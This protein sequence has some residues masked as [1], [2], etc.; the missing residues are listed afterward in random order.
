MKCVVNKKE[1]QRT[2]EKI[3]LINSKYDKHLRFTQA[4]EIIATNNTIKIIADNT[5]QRA[6]IT[7]SAN[8]IEPGK[9]AVYT[10]DL[11]TILKTVQT[12]KITLETQD[13]ILIINSN[14][15]LVS[16]IADFPEVPEP[17]MLQSI[18]LNS[19]TL[20]NVLTKTIFAKSDNK[21]SKLNSV[22]FD[23][24]EHDLKIVACNGHRLAVYTIDNINTN[25]SVQYVL[26]GQG[27]EIL[28]KLLKNVKTNIAISF[29]AKSAKFEFN[30]I[31]LYI[32]IFDDFK[33]FDYKS[34]LNIDEK[35]VLD[36]DNQTLI[37]ALNTIEA[38]NVTRYGKT[39]ENYNIVI[40]DIENNQCKISSNEYC[41]SDTLHCYIHNQDNLDLKIG[42][43]IKY[44]TDVLKT[45]NNTITISFKDPFSPAVI[46]DNDTNYIYLVLPVKLP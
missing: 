10:K 11:L 1:L 27:V 37:T 4:I 16:D 29:G 43:R 17:Q 20:Y 22:L 39:N 30:N 38:V 6:T 12:N 31:A 5:K 2:L 18:T 41:Y 32:D 15:K 45:L 40:F 42:F 36:I 46:S 21:T 34:V 28:Y 3:K 26:N 8:V 33:Y 24:T 7:I 19:Q 9:I 25:H 23:I 35:I 14:L 44:L 13:N